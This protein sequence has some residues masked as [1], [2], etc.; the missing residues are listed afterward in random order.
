MKNLPKLLLHTCCGPCAIHVAR[1]LALDYE[2]SLYFFNPNIQPEIEYQARLA[3]IKKWAGQDGFD[4]IV[5]PYDIRPWL[6]KVHGFE[7]EPEGGQRCLLCYEFRLEQTAR[8]A[9]AHGFEIFTTTLSISPH[10]KA[11]NINPI[12]LA[13]AEKY[14]SQFLVADWKKQDGFKHS[15]EL[16]REQGFYRQD[17]CGCAFSR[18]DRLMRNNLK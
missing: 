17:Y 12:G 3:E 10:K 2:V 11:S 13:M 14:G 9:Q 1:K 15:C 16:S 8:Y 7:K 5:E 18:A 4:M 6:D